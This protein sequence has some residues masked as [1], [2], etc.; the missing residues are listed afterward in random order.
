MHRESKKRIVKLEQRIWAKL[1]FWPTDDD[2]FL[3]ALGITERQKEKYKRIN[4]G[5]VA[6]YDEIEALNSTAATDWADFEGEPGK[7]GG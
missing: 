4:P 5:G 2:G 1:T 6:G 7:E 3:E